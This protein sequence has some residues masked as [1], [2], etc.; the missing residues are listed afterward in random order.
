MHDNDYIKNEKIGM[1][2][3]RTEYNDKNFIQFD[4][5]VKEKDINNEQWYLDT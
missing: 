4:K 5:K 3:E 2:K 1:G